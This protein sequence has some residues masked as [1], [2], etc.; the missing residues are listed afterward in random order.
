MAKTISMTLDSRSI[1]KAIKEI[2]KYK[3][4]LL[5]K[6][7]LLLSRLAELGANDAQVRFSSA[8]YDGIN[9]V[10]VTHSESGNGYVIEAQ[11]QA[12]AF[13]EFGSGVYYNPSEPYPITR[14]EG[15]VA[16]GQYG[17]GRG[18]RRAWFY[19]GDPGTNGEVNEKGYVKTRGNPANMPMWYAT[20]EM[21]NSIITI[22]KEV[23]N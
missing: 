16:I 6:E 17:K 11:G 19:K 10:T 23:F 9:D 18:K 1:N 20:E 4:W 15:V 5:E 22:A 3:Q 7:K 12:V 8:I 13:I 21:R 14:P 2:E